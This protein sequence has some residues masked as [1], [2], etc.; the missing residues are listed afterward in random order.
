MTRNFVD[1]VL[2]V[3]RLI[4]VPA[5]VLAVSVPASAQRGQQR[6]QQSTQQRTL[7]EWRGNVD[8]EVRVQMQR[9]RTSVVPMGPREMTGYSNARALSSIP[10]SN[11]YVSV[12]MRQGRGRADVVQQPSAQNGYSTIIRVRDSQSGA[13]RYDIVAYWQPTGNSRY[14]NSGV[15]N[16]GR[17]DNYNQYGNNGRYNDGRYYDGRDG[18]YERYGAY[19][20]RVVVVRRPVYVVRGNGA[21]TVPIPP[22]SIAPPRHAQPRQAQLRY[23]DGHVQAGKTLPGTNHAVRTGKALPVPARQARPVRP[24]KP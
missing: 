7:F 16:N 12:Q 14:G 20:E 6:G 18:N 11:G 10:S 1:S 5:A 13:G 2:R 22:R 8:M 21:R 15:Y 3:T 23:P 9:G 4:A 24:G 19:P 17:D